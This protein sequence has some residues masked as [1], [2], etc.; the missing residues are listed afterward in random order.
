[1]PAVSPINPRAAVEHYHDGTK[2]HFNRFARSLG[3][4]DWASQ[5]RPFR[6]YTGAS[7]FPLYPAPSAKADDYAPLPVTY[8]QL[9]DPP[10]APAPLTAAALGDVLRHALGL[11]AWEQFG[12]SRG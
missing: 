7:A 5:P 10:T 6:G 2:H 9:F 8:G 11:S 12:A 1:M 4:L 3:Y